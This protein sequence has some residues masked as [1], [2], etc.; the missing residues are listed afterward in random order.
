MFYNDYFY[1]IMDYRIEKALNYVEENMHLHLLLADLARVACLSPSQ[2]HRLFKKHT[3]TTPFKFIEEVKV[4]Q[5]LHMLKTHKIPIHQL[6]T[7][8]GYNDYETFSRV[9]KKHFHISPHDIRAISISIKEEIKPE[10]T[11]EIIFTA[12]DSLENEADLLNKLKELIR[13]KK[14]KEKDLPNA[15]L[16]TIERNSA[17]QLKDVELIKKKFL[18]SRDE[19]IW[20]T[21]LSKY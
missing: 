10:K 2:F 11:T 13:A 4:K 8:L 20:K 12:I 21:L 9:F 3:G 15:V 19:K 18:I 5:A 1:S 7:A 16:F 6:A 17:N 14:I